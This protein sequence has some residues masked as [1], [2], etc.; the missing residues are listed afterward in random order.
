M[1]PIGSAGRVERCLPDAWHPENR[2]KLA[3]EKECLLF[4]QFFYGFVLPGKSVIRFF[5]FRAEKMNA[6]C[7]CDF[8]KEIQN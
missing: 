8:A 7:G 2:K 1:K 6:L 5:S 4:R 3:R